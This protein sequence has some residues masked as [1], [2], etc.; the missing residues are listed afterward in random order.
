MI[1]NKLRKPATGKTKLMNEKAYKE[2]N[3]EKLKEEEKLANMNQ[4]V[5]GKLPVVGKEHSFIP[6]W[7]L[8]RYK[9]LLEDDMPDTVHPKLWEQGKMNIKTG[10]FKITENIFQIRGYDLANME[11]IRG[12]TGWIVVGCLTS[13]ET[14][15]A[16][17]DFVAKNFEDRPVSAIIISHSHVDHY[18]GVLGVLNYNSIGDVKVYV[19]KGFSTAV[20]EENVNAGV[21]M[22][23]RSEYMYG[24]ILLRDEKGQID[25]GIGKY[26]SIGT[27]TLT[28]KIVEIT[29]GS[30]DKYCEKIIDGVRV[31]F[32]LSPDSEAPA[33]M[34]FY[35][36]EEKSLCIAEMC[37]ATLHNIYTLR[38][39]QVRDPV[40][41]ADHIQEAIDLFGAD[42]TSVF[43]VHT[44]SRYGNEYCLDYLSKQRDLYQYMNDQTLRLI[45]KGYTIDEVGRMIEFPKS[46]NDEWYN[47]PFYGTINHNVKAIYQK[48][49]GWFNGNP[50]D[51]NLLLPQDSAKKYVEYMGG[52]EEVIKKAAKSY[53]LGEYQWV[54][55]VTKQ[56]I[57]ANPSNKKAKMLCADALEQ[58]GYIAE[59]GP[60]RNIYLMG[61][62]ELRYGKLPL[63]DTTIT[64]QTLD[65]IPLEKVL[66]LL[67]IRIEGIK[68]GDMDY[69]I[70]FII[71]D[72]N[73]KACTEVKR[74]IFRYLSDEICE[75]ADVTVTMAKSILYE[76]ATT[77][78]KPKFSEIN[79]EGDRKK[80]LLFLYTHDTIDPVFNIMTPLPKEEQ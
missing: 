62:F 19:P 25:C 57:F 78:N 31:Q 42:L 71:P 30:D 61:S 9:F 39:A 38:G 79:V 55:E 8:K 33:E 34:S 66:Y 26:A 21:A 24:E 75:D 15:T 29:K 3:W 67:S 14:A 43:C 59:S 36:P 54:A 18:G 44:W 60:W 64:S 52:E 1:F 77:N 7:N 35:F 10:L 51:L 73:E 6:V 65:N 48:Y 13:E 45:N 56:V 22:T 4:I 58:L 11:L 72:R 17:L 41:W 76:L 50:V 37:T 70:N 23:R 12:K 63:I 16:A 20:I 2:M 68:A 74:G 47:S 46:L 27:V 28:D 32:H 80:W 49:M 5:D 40:A 69:K 53:E